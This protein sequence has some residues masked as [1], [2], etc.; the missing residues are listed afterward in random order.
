MIRI[1]RVSSTRVYERGV[2]LEEPRGTRR[3]NARERE[4]S[5]KVGRKRLNATRVLI[6]RAARARWKIGR[7]RGL[8]NP[9]DK[10]GKE[11]ER[12]RESLPHYP[13]TLSKLRASADSSFL[14]LRFLFPFPTFFSP[15]VYRLRA[16]QTYGAL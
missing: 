16:R 15:S 4:R 2:L 8:F 11:R 14:L 9:S 5:G 10:P 7:K 13:S 12:E 3:V 1:E 6:T